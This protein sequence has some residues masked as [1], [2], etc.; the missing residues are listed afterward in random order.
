MNGAPGEG[1]P[2]AAEMADSA[3]SLIVTSPLKPSQFV[4]GLYA[5][6]DVT[7]DNT[8]DFDDLV[9]VATAS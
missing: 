3:F 7:P 9:A 6:G 2:F 8:R 5:R 1:S 4:F